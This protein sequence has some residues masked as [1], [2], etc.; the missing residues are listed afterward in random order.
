MKFDSCIKAYKLNYYT[1][2][3]I[4][5]NITN[6][7]IFYIFKRSGCKQEIRIYDIKNEII[8]QNNFSSVKVDKYFDFFSW[9]AEKIDFYNLWNKHVK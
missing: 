4:I 9:N 5:K 3:V 2:H 6:K 7:Y 8:Y 1:S